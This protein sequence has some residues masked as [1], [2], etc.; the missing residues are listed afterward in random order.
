MELVCD[1]EGLGVD[2]KR[3]LTLVPDPSQ[4]EEPSQQDV[5][6]LVHTTFVLTTPSQDV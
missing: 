3:E 5:W 1:Y 2:P 6:H 4:V